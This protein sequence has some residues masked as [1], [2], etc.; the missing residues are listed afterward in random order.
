M[1]TSYVRTPIPVCTCIPISLYALKML[2]WIP[3]CLPEM[4]ISSINSPN[5]LFVPHLPLRYLLLTSLII[6][7]SLS[8]FTLSHTLFLSLPLCICLF[9]S[10]PLSLSF[11]HPLFTNYYC[12]LPPLS[13]FLFVSLS[14]LFY[15]V[16]HSPSPKT[17]TLS[18]HSPPLSHTL[19]LSLPLCICLFVSFPLSLPLF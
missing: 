12:L 8:L 18:P 5:W 4:A 11:D 16:S 14:I 7:I 3:D 6:P 2:S 19:F 9:V 1:Y 17:Q 10:F 13:S 15:Y